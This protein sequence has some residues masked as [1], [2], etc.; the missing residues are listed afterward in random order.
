MGTCVDR[1]HH[2]LGNLR[3]GRP[4]VVAHSARILG[5]SPASLKVTRR[6]VDLLDDDLREIHR[7]ASPVDRLTLSRLTQP[8]APKPHH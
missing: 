7:N 3:P 5:R 1:A 6:C 4:M 8:S 2:Q